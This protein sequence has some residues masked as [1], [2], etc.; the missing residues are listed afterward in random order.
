MFGSRARVTWESSWS[1]LGE[2]RA[3]FHCV[4][5]QPKFTSVSGR[6]GESRHCSLLVLPQLRFLSAECVL[7]P[8][9]MGDIE[10]DHLMQLQ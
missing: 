9:I 7:V 5:S 4:G 3:R 6:E 1:R 8:K 10:Q 2:L